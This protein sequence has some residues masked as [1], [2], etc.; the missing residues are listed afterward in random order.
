MRPLYKIK[1]AIDVPDPFL[2]ESHRPEEIVVRAEGER[3]GKDPKEIFFGI[4]EFHNRFVKIFQHHEG[5][6][7]AIIAL[8]A[9][10][11]QEIGKIVVVMLDELFEIVLC[12]HASLFLFH[13]PTIGT[14]YQE[15]MKRG[16]PPA[17]M[18][19][20]RILPGKG[21]PSYSTFGLIS[22]KSITVWPGSI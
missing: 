15:N 1:K 2:V 4:L 7:Q 12:K 6:D 20:Q 5:R 3:I 14:R 21:D 22:L 11:D 17:R 10:A 16:R 9:G 18:T 13:R 19:V 8:L